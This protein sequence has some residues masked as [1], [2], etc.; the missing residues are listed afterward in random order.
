MSHSQVSVEYV[1]S[2]SCTPSSF[3]F[4]PIP[5]LGIKDCTII[6]ISGWDFEQVHSVSVACLF[7][8]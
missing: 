6:E 2:L 5:I 1:K 4:S 3:S 7:R 8:N